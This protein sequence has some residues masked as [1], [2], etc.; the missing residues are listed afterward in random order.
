MHHRPLLT[1]FVLAWPVLALSCLLTAPSDEE[2]VGSCED[3]RKNGGETDVDCGG[4]CAPCGTNRTCKEHED[5]A[6]GVCLVGVCERPSCSDGVQNGSETDVDCGGLDEGCNYCANGRRCLVDDDCDSLIC[7]NDVCDDG[8]SDGI[9][10]GSEAD[11]DCGEFCP[12]QCGP[13]QACYDD[14]DCASR[15]CDVEEGRCQ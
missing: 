11:I 6:T 13:G 3:D 9:L 7:T 14:L 12:L 8:C 2:L 10:N 1:P 4:P 5:C 15:L